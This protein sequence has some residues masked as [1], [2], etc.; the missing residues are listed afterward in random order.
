[1]ACPLGALCITFRTSEPDFFCDLHTFSSQL[2][3]YN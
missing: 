2:Q 3:K 1:M